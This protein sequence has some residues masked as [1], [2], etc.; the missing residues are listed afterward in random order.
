MP[1]SGS[2]TEQSVMQ[3]DTGRLKDFHQTFFKPNNATLVVVGDVSAAE[4]QPLLEKQF[5]RWKGGDVPQKNIAFV[6]SRTEPT[7]YLMDRPDSEQSVIFAGHVAP[8]KNNEHE[9]AIA[10]M[11]EVLGGSFNARINMNLREDKHWSYG[12]RSLLID[13]EGQRP[14]LVYAPVQTDKTSE[15][16]AEIYREVTEIRGERPPTPDEV[17]RAKDKST[18]TLAGRWETANAVADSLSEMVRFGLPDDYWNTYP[19][20]VRALSDS[21][22]SEAASEVVQPGGMV[23][24]VVG[25]R[26]RIEGGIR[27]LGYGDIVLMDADGNVLEGSGAAN[28]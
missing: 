19:D 8:P 4:L 21:Q 26:A 16:M 15:S 24:V 5:R 10:A 13:A 2:G 22:I 23:W 11:N 3:I 14:F 12:A 20:R 17:L 1:L 7:V 9:I 25:D 28:D 27:A 6:G 18:L